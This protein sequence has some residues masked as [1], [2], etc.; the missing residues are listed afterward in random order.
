MFAYIFL[1]ATLLS[2]RLKRSSLSAGIAIFSTILGALTRETQALAVSTLLALALF[3]PREY[4]RRFWMLGAAAGTAFIAI[5]L[6][7]RFILGFQHGVAEKISLGGQFR[8]EMVP[9]YLMLVFILLFLLTR[10]YEDS[11]PFWL[12]LLLFAP[13]LLTVILT[14]SY[15]EIRLAVPLC[16]CLVFLYNELA[17]FHIRIGADHPCPQTD[18]TT[19]TIRQPPSPA[20]APGSADP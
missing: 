4:A 13:Y 1:L 18:V 15:A 10:M 6:A 3:L 11:R 16:I 20:P 9:L 2:S 7:L 5:Y 19:P 8:F 14:G 17:V 12:A